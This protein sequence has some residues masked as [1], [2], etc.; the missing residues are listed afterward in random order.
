VDYVYNYSTPIPTINSN[1][2]H[3]TTT[4]TNCTLPTPFY[5]IAEQIEDMDVS[6]DYLVY[7]TST[8]LYRI[9]LD[10][11]D[12]TT[13]SVLGVSGVQAVGSTIY[14]NSGNAIFSV[15]VTGANSRQLNAAPTGLCVC[16]PV[17]TG[18]R[19]QNCNNG[20][21]QWDYNGRPNGVPP[22][23]SGNP[24]TCVQDFQC[25]NPPYTVCFGTCQCRQNFTGTLCDQCAY[26]VTWNEFGFPQCQ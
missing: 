21:V 9:R 2:Y 25:N 20:Q 18:D 24:E 3:G 11:T 19:C 6:G 5:T 16:R 23:G 10:G 14:F 8:G 13:L 17:F 26:Q 1:I 7:G 22:D 4:C 15:D 12:R